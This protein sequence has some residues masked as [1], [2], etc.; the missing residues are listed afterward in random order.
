M[1]FYVIFE[2]DEEDVIDGIGD[3]V[4][5]GYPPEDYM[6]SLYKDKDCLKRLCNV[7]FST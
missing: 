5:E 7:Y 2:V 6:H 4:Q 3:D 1:G